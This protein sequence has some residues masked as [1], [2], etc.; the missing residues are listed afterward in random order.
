MSEILKEN[1]TRAEVWMRLLYMLLFGMIYGV[2]KFLVVAVVVL[3]FGFVL[4]SART[5]ANLLRFGA[6]LSHFVYQILLYLSFNTELRPFPFSDWP[7]TP[8]LADTDG[9]ASSKSPAPK[10]T[11]RPRATRKTTKKKVSRKKVAPSRAD[12]KIDA[13]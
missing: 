2:A 12:G 10:A 7:S 11:S 5:N 6:E 1:I 3:Q 9:S 8:T 4:L 13:S